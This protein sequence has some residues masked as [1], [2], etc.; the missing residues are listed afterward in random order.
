MPKHLRPLLFAILACTLASCG[1]VYKPVVQQG[2]LLTKKDLEQ[3]KPGMT[4]NQ[5]IALLGTPAISSPFDHDRWDYLM[6]TKIRGK[7]TVEHK[8]TLYFEYGALART[9]GQYYGQSARK[10]QQ[11][12]E[13][14]KKYHIETPGKGARGDK[15]HDGDGGDA[16]GS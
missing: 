3:L 15:N 1:L 16:N 13:Q 6:T 2:N 7:K 14:S 10:E 11:L 4:K 5:V 9:E 12:L 8:L